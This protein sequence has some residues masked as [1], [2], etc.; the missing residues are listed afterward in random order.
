[1]DRPIVYPAALPQ[2]SDV[3]SVAQDA[4]IGLGYALQAVM[5]SSTVVAGL[6]CTPTSPASLAVNVAPGSIMA[7]AQTD[8]TAYSTLP[9]NANSLMQ[10]GIVQTTTLF[11]IAAPSTSGQSIN[12]LIEAAFSQTDGNSTVLPYY[13][14]AN[15]SQPY[16]GPNNSGTAQNTIRYGACV[17]QLKAGAP[18]ATG[19]QVTPAVDSGYV[20]LWVITVANGQS[21]IVSGNIVE[22]SGAPF[23]PFTLPQLAAAQAAAGSYAALNGSS[24]EQFNVEAGT[25]ATNAVNVAQLGAVTTQIATAPIYVTAT[26]TTN[27]AIPSWA[28]SIG[29]ELWGGGGSGSVSTTSTSRGAGGGAGGCIKGVVASGFT[30][31]GTLAGFTAGGTL[32]VTI[33]A[34]GAGVSSGAGLAGQASTIGSFATANGGGNGG[35]SVFGN[36]AGGIGGT[37]SAG[38]GLSNYMVFGGQDGGDGSSAAYN[39][40]GNGGG[41]GGGRGANGAPAYSGKAPGAGGGGCGVGFVSGS[42][43]NGAAIIKFY[44]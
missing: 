1:M 18:A 30:A 13:N 34:G 35:G 10:Q 43:S 33:G 11:N 40:G 8:A 42:G 29:F 20:G 26:G 28:A 39:P 37:A 15:P 4:M 41:I 21:T 17:L 12:Y 25:T 3:L 32:A 14:A 2:A 23:L 38:S 5:G 7:L 36:Y 6:A 16:S 44:P 24:S 19:S 27:V 9:A 31:G 22:Y